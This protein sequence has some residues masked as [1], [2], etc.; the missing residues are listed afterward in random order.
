MYQV[1]LNAFISV[2]YQ[3]LPEPVF[4]QLEASFYLAQLEAL[5]GHSGSSNS[6][7]TSTSKSVDPQQQ[8]QQLLR[9]M[10][11]V[12]QPMLHVSSDI[13]CDYVT[14]LSFFFNSRHPQDFTSPT[15]RRG[16]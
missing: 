7:S 16:T 15:S 13:S 4:A 14:C 5:L 11:H 1:H 6:T 10:R 2:Y 3:W 8:Q 12:Q 9:R